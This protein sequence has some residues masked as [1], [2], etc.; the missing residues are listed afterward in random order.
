MPTG[1]TCGNCN[2]FQKIKAWGG[3]RNG[4]CEALDYNVHADS[5]YA[6]YCK[7]YKAKCYS[8]AERRNSKQ[9]MYW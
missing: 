5:S 7:Y 6:K 3:A 4:I 2:S 8:I 9:K 1:K